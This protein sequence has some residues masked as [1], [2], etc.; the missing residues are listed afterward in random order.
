MPCRR[1]T[2]ALYVTAT[3]LP[4]PQAADLVRAMAGPHRLPDALHL[5]DQLTRTRP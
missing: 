1:S 4:L 5:V 2:S 3:D